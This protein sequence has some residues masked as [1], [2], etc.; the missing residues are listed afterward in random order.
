[1]G[2]AMF[3]FSGANCG[4]NGL[5]LGG[6]YLPFEYDLS[7]DDIVDILPDSLKVTLRIRPHVD[8]TTED[9]TSLY[10]DIDRDGGRVDVPGEVIVMRTWKRNDGASYHGKW[11][12]RISDTRLDPPV[13]QMVVGQAQQHQV[14]SES[15]SVSVSPSYGPPKPP[16]NVKLALAPGLV[17]ARTRGKTTANHRSRRAWATATR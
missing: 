13:Q 16:D 12:I 4:L 17:K 8:S 6:S 2:Q 7:K 5:T 11:A 3:R 15:E 1:M 10:G 14:V 9:S